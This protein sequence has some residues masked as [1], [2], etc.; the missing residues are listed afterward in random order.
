M[1]PGL[2]VAEFFRLGSI[3]RNAYIHAPKLLNDRLQL[4]QRPQIRFAGQITGTEGYVESAATGLLVGHMLAFELKGGCLPLPPPTSA[5]GALAHYLTGGPQKDYQPM[6]INFGIFPSLP[7][8]GKRIKRE[9]RKQAYGDRARA[10]FN[11][12]LGEVHL[13]TH[14]VQDGLREPPSPTLGLTI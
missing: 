6:N 9:F 8:Q 13:P 4:K 10:A 2:E 12:W 14:L 11:N 7:A 3:H 1:I 5:L